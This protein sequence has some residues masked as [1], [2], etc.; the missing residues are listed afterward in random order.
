MKRYKWKRSTFAAQRDKNILKNWE[1]GLIDNEECAR[2]ISENNG[3]PMNPEYLP[4]IA[5][6]LGYIREMEERNEESDQ[7]D[8]ELS[9]DDNG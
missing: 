2:L 3:K 7:R 5:K 8:K 6:A 4:A 1:D 9:E